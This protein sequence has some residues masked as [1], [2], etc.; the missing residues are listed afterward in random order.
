VVT[1]FHSLVSIRSV[2]AIE[3]MEYSRRLSDAPLKH[4]DAPRYMGERSPRQVYVSPDVV[5][6]ELKAQLEQKAEKSHDT[7]GHPDQP[8]VR[9]DLPTG[10]L[11]IGEHLYG[12]HVQETDRRVSWRDEASDHQFGT[13]RAVVLGPPGQGKSWLVEMT[14]SNVAQVAYRHLHDQSM[15]IAQIPLVVSVPLPELSKFRSG[16]GENPGETLR[17]ALAA[18][19]SKLYE[20]DSE[21]KKSCG[22]AARYLAEH[23]HERRTW[24]ILDALDEVSEGDD[25]RCLYSLLGALR[26]WHCRVLITSRPYGYERR[27]LPFDVSE[28]RLAPFSSPQIEQFVRQW[29][30]DTQQQNEMLTLLRASFALQQISQ[31]PFLLTLAC[32]LAE[33]EPVPCD[34][35]RGQLYERTL[36][37]MF[38][39]SKE[40]IVDGKKRAA[41]WRKKLNQLAW[42]MI[43]QDARRPR[44][45]HAELLDFLAESEDRPPP[46]GGAKDPSDV[47]IA[48]QL[49][50]ELC[51]QRLLVPV[52]SLDA[53]VFPHRSFAEFAAARYLAEKVNH[54][55][56]KKA[57]VR[58]P[59][60]DKSWPILAWL[61]R[62]SWDPKLQEAI[63]FVAGM[64]ADPKPLLLLLSE[65]KKDDLFRHR[66]G[67]A[68]MCLPEIDLTKRSDFKSLVSRIA[69][70]LLVAWSR[71]EFVCPHLNR[72]MHAIASI[73]APITIS[74]LSLLSSP[75]RP[76]WRHLVSAGPFAFSELICKLASDL[77]TELL[78]IVI[79]VTGGAP[80]LQ[81]VL[82]AVLPALKTESRQAAVEIFRCFGQAGASPFV[83]DTLRA[84][85]SDTIRRQEGYEWD[86]SEPSDSTIDECEATR[87]AALQALAAIGPAASDPKTLES[88]LELIRY[89]IGPHGTGVRIGECRR[90]AAFAFG[91]VASQC[92]TA[93]LDLVLGEMFEASDLLGRDVVLTDAAALAVS[94]IC[95]RA[96]TSVILAHL[97]NL[98]ALRSV[99]A[100]RAVISLG[101]ASASPLIQDQ[102]IATLCSSDTEDERGQILYRD[103]S[104]N[105]R[106]LAVLAFRA[107]W[108]ACDLAR[109]ERELANH[110]AGPRHNP[111]AGEVLALVTGKPAP[112]YV[113]TRLAWKVLS[114]YLEDE[115]YEFDVLRE[116][117]PRHRHSFAQEV[118]APNRAHLKVKEGYDD[119]LDTARRLAD[120]G[121][122]GLGPDGH[123]GLA[124][125]L[126][127]DRG[128]YPEIATLALAAVGGTAS[129]EPIVNCIIE[130]MLGRKHIHGATTAL[131]SFGSAAC[132][133]TALSR[134]SAALLSEDDKARSAAAHIL[135]CLGPDAAT[136]SIGADL[137]Q[138]IDGAIRCNHSTELKNL[139][140]A[141]E[142]LGARISRRSLLDHLRNLL[143]RHETL[144]IRLAAWRAMEAVGGHEIRVFGSFTRAMLD[145]KPSQWRVLTLPELSA[146]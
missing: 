78:G 6:R 61:D 29:S 27:A 17:R 33:K 46:L 86:E 47:T 38:E 28:Y 72:A 130:F 73:D 54:C 115:D 120:L 10:A 23:A 26:S 9:I 145:W 64:L 71:T 125:K 117:W 56:W 143:E 121:R 116:E 80:R 11:E 102:I 133:P 113:L 52:P 14:A 48:C 99:A 49:R 44:I 8:P 90:A 142:V 126:N 85:I 2:L 67:L 75:L 136:E 62:K 51:R 15:N 118:D 88:L 76:A 127:S 124:E 21:E 87:I 59:D 81:N 60:R 89:P 138:A 95:E 5:K 119:F 22:K 79:D 37:L 134:V 18:T 30:A 110:Q 84:I 7:Q 4:E 82:A 83:L 43:S 42:R 97:A 101:R 91:S 123:R 140:L 132:Y 36:Q 57:R 112:E 103:M 3:L 109:F 94:A 68:A 40:V 129:S 13:W 65:K 20:Q 107:I 31:N 35:T 131:K 32:A 39:G 34:I 141:A 50:D 104:E 69:G 63:S 53:Y 74:R 108:G 25:L 122:L 45:L 114:P 100:T 96:A 146:N 92:P 93:Y 98:I 24:L 70:S 105:D 144:E 77:D 137:E 135:A 16:E 66:L 19:V 1:N 111:Q 12:E 58:N 41:E 106:E 139:L 128:S 55:G